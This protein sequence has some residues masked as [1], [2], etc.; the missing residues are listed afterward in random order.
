MRTRTRPQKSI[1]AISPRTRPRRCISYREPSVEESEY[2][3]DELYPVAPQ[4]KRVR[5]THSSRSSINQQRSTKKK[6]KGSPTVIKQSADKNVGETMG[7]AVSTIVKICTE[8]NTEKKIP[9]WQTLPYDIL[10]QIF[11]YAAQPLWD[12]WDDQLSPTPAIAW[13]L[14]T[15]LVCKSFTEPALSILYY[16]PPLQPPRRARRL[17]AHL[18]SQ[19]TNHSFNYRSKIKYLD[20]EVLSIL[21]R[22]CS[23]EAPFTLAT[24]LPY[25]PQLRGIGLNLIYDLP[26]NNPKWEYGGKIL[27]MVTVYSSDMLDSLDASQ[28]SLL[29]WKWN[30]TLIKAKQNLS[31]Q[32]VHCRPSFR[33]IREL[34]LLG[35]SPNK[36]LTKSSLTDAL[37]ALPKLKRVSVE[38]SDDCTLQSLPNY[39]EAL[40]IVGC[41]HLTSED[42][43]L[44]LVNNGNNLREL[45]LNHNRSLS[46]AFVVNLA[47][48]CPKLETLKMNLRY[49]NSF[50]T[51]TDTEPKF[52]VLLFPH[53][54]P[55]WPSTLQTLD[56]QYVR[57][58]QSDAAAMFFQSLV[59]S[60]RALPYLRKLEIKAIV[61]IDWR[62]RASF[63]HKWESQLKQVFLR[64]SPPPDPRLKSI[65]AFYASDV[66]LPQVEEYDGNITKGEM[67]SDHSKARPRRNR[68]SS[69]VAA[70]NKAEENDEDE[71]DDNNEIEIV[72]KRRSSRL[73]K[74]DE[75]AYNCPGEA[76]ARANPPRRVR[77]RKRSDSASSSDDSALEDETGSHVATSQRKH[78]GEEKLFM[79]GLCDIVSIQIDNLRPAEDQY[80]E[81]DFLDEEMSGDED[82]NGDDTAEPS[83]SRPMRNSR[84]GRYAW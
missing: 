46:M 30:F 82:W 37:N 54:V 61:D 12:W 69:R 21:A 78:N 67:D 25:T 45:V 83:S 8:R 62:D 49:Y 26:M 74:Q 71:S 33:N 17:L 4:P 2:S 35:Y 41:L 24:L 53:E 59:D 31:L 38:F 55:T 10:L 7:G 57:K 48:M 34:T 63:R 64:H 56:L 9:Q 5:T 76:T 52:E 18:S 70:A 50:V 20:V 3:L 60:A 66:I 1:A 22:K 13:L 19:D 23:G 36:S 29:S 65:Q 43:R 40:Q 14:K 16:A 68:Y 75:D 44:F 27:N 11:H 42:L 80:H 84:P 15:A 73:Q 77:K 81:S 32:E 58:W 51:I 28:I 39:L 47:A 72:P 6:K 79:Q